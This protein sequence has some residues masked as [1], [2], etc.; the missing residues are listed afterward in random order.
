MAA[1]FV[2]DAQ[3]TVSHIADPFLGY[4]TITL[5]SD[6]RV[7]V[8]AK[9]NLT[10]GERVGLIFKSLPWPYQ[11]QPDVIGSIKNSAGEVIRTL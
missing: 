4:K 7:V 8:P 1:S 10:L 5:A 6:R 2:P 9:A 11:D 3:D